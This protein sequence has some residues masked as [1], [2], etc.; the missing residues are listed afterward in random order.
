MGGNPLIYAHILTIWHVSRENRPLQGSEHCYTWTGMA[1]V[2]SSTSTREVSYWMAVEFLVIISLIND[3]GR[4][5]LAYTELQVDFTGYLFQSMQR[6]PWDSGSFY[7][8]LYSSNGRKSIDI[9]TYPYNISLVNYMKD[10]TPLVYSY[11]LDAYILYAHWVIYFNQWVKWAKMGHKWAKIQQ[12]CTCSFIQSH[13]NYKL[14]D[15]QP[16]NVG[17]NETN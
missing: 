8:R 4:L 3:L 6:L 1:K 9:C 14:N 13:L 16:M 7:C 5:W 12:I 10:I 11:M 17:I 2:L 15:S